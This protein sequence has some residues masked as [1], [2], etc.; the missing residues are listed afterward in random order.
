LVPPPYY[1]RPSQAGLLKYFHTLADTASVPLILYNIPY[2]TGIELELETIRT[3]AQ[4]ER[5]TGIKDCGGSA[6]TTLNLIAD[7]KLD[8]LAEED[9]QILATLCLGGAGAIAAAAHIR[10]DLFVR[11]AQHMQSGE[12]AGARQ[13]FYRLLPMIQL[14]FQEPNPAP[15]KMALPMMGWMRDEL[16][17][18]MQMASEKMRE[19]LA[20]ELKRLDCL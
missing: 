11:V 7:A 17:A 14:L 10:P 2:R 1:I 5:V 15:V 3:L 16:R 20:H 12:L 8:V 19:Q 4:H 13:L 18:P 9:H 6:A